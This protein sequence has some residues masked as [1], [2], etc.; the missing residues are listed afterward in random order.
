MIL[1]WFSHLYILKFSMQIFFVFVLFAN[2]TSCYSLIFV[3]CYPD[4]YFW[5]SLIWPGLFLYPCKLSTAK[6]IYLYSYINILICCTH[7]H[8]HSLI[9][10]L[11]ISTNVVFICCLFHI[12]HSS[13]NFIPGRQQQT[14]TTLWENISQFSTVS[15]MNIA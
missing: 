4:K 5:S 13:Y 15:R 11:M 2:L 8:C 9:P 10:D 7:S 14:K 1:E 3:V 6:Q 12:P